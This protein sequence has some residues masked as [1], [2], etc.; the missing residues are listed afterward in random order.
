MVGSLG[1]FAENTSVKG[2]VKDSRT[3]EAIIGASV[4][5]QGTNNGVITDINGEYIIDVPVDA[6]LSV[7]YVGY[8]TSVINV[9]GKNKIDIPMEENTIN[10]KELVVI[11]YG[12]ESRKSNLSVAIS[13][14]D[15]DEASKSRGTDLVG[16]MQG[17]IAGVSIANNSGDPLSAPTVTIRGK[18]S[19]NGEQPLYVVDGVE[20]APFNMKDE[21]N[22]TVLKDDASVAFYCTNGGC[23]GISL[24]RRTNR[25]EGPVA[26]F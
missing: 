16:A 14:M 22:I 1:V 9:N 15:L 12:Q 10:L 3:G 7:S 6:S 4:I 25:K 19:R 18:G 2:L 21:E 5:Q 11:G 13:K 20:G 23:V 17:R 26:V 8:I 24:R